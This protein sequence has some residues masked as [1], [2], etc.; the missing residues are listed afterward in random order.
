MK[1][2]IVNLDELEAT[3]ELHHGDRFDAT[4]API[5]SRIGARKLGYNVTAVA[6]GKRAF[7]FH[8]HHVNEELFFVLEGEGM[9]RLGD[10]EHPVRKGDFVCCP[11]GGAAHQFIN[12][13]AS[14]LRYLAVSTMI[15]CD[16]WH[17]PDSKKFGVIAGR[18]PSLPPS[19]A[20]FTSRFVGDDVGLDYWHGE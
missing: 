14:P 5:G 7:P 17:Y 10:E 12:T 13:G 16:V 4:L 20:T 9:L 3:R 8:N 6:P 18:D 2:N 1:S 19:Q 11:A 15:D